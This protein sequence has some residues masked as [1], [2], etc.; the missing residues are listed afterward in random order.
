MW[1][2]IAHAGGHSAH[3]DFKAFV[4]QVKAAFTAVSA[5]DVKYMVRGATTGAARLAP[6]KP[7][8]RMD[9]THT[10]ACV[11][12]SCAVA[13]VQVK[14]GN[15]L[16]P[17]LFEDGTAYGDPVSVTRFDRLDFVFVYG[18]PSLMPWMKSAQQVRR[19]PRGGGAPGLRSRYR[20]SLT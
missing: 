16:R 7:H 12:S 15:Q 5:P 14:H 20:R 1:V 13:V 19:L 6:P 8:A 9:P 3:M 2:L 10:R 18:D 11:A 17:W 4:A